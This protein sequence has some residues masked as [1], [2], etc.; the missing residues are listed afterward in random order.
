MSEVATPAPG[1]VAELNGAISKAFAAGG[2][3]D[4]HRFI[5]QSPAQ[6]LS[7]GE[8][9]L[10]GIET[11]LET[12]SLSAAAEAAQL[13]E[14]ASDALE[15]ASGTQTTRLDT[16]PRTTRRLGGWRARFAAF[17]AGAAAVVAAC[18]GSSPATT[19]APKATSI[20]TTTPAATETV[21][22]IPSATATSK[23][24]TPATEAGLPLTEIFNQTDWPKSPVTNQQFEDAINSMQSHP[25]LK[26]ELIPE[27]IKN[28]EQGDPNLDS[29]S[30][31]E[32]YCLGFGVSALVAWSQGD[33]NA[34]AAFKTIYAYMV[35]PNGG[36]ANDD[37]ANVDK[38]LTKTLTQLNIP[39]A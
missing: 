17:T 39:T 33:P 20:P 32:P 27:M 24:T 31:R 38:Y 11:N 34:E 25:R 29:R 6:S 15:P 30:G 19:E 4:S 26:E 22:P 36:F 21:K 12:G 14:L 37:K 1:T 23:E 18:G 16:Q 7:A 3:P 13:T 8:A 2:L 9:A 28:C 35:S 10:A 5:P